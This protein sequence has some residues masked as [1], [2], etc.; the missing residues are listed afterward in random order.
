LVLAVWGLAF[1]A[2]TDDIRE[3]PAI[4]CVNKLLERGIKIKAYDPEAASSAK[5]ALGGKIDIFGNGYDAL[6]GADALVILTE[7]QE[8]RNP[9]FEVISKK[10]KPVR[11]SASEVGKPVIFDGRN[12]YDP[13]VVRKAGF[14]YY[15]VG[16]PAVK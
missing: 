5:A 10:L 14:E 12:L 2:K 15:S 9:D 4:N 16:R 3:S 1:K 6:D 7:W 8:F 11:R 13:D